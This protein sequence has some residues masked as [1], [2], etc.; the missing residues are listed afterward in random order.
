M[1]TLKTA[2][3]PKTLEFFKEK[4]SL[5]PT[6]KPKVFEEFQKHSTFSGQKARDVLTSG[7]IPPFRVRNISQTYGFTPPVGDGVLLSRTFIREL[8]VLLDDD[9][10]TG[11][12][13]Y[14]EVRRKGRLM[15]EGTILHELVHWCRKY[16][17]GY[18][19][20]RKQE[21]AEA[22]RFEQHAY[23]F[24]L[25]VEGLGLAQYMPETSKTPRLGSGLDHPR[26]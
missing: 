10:V 20:D 9:T 23:G 13:N 6:D 3:Y 19:P 5:I 14:Y 7:F 4:L 16:N 11:V 17:Y 25:T 2:G 15:L 24:V 12:Y 1:A 21:E 26:L 8:E 18:L 22:Q